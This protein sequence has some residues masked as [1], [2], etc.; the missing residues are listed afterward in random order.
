[1]AT[2]Y[3]PKFLIIHSPTL[4]SPRSITH[5]CRWRDERGERE[6]R[7]GL[8]SFRFTPNARMHNLQAGED[9]HHHSFLTKTCLLTDHSRVTSV[10]SSTSDE[11][12]I[13]LM[14]CLC[15]QTDASAP[16]SVLADI[17]NLPASV[18]PSPYHV[19]Q[20]AVANADCYTTGDHFNLKP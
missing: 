12:R 14:L 4:I 19:H 2:G 7:E 8:L 13:F 10:S 16:V 6:E 5:G 9:R 15:T 18:L 17:Q 20:F 11:N 1:M 3:V